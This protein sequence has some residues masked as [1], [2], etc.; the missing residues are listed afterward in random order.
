MKSTEEYIL[1][2]KDILESKGC[3]I[4]EDGIVFDRFAGIVLHK[5]IHELA[6]YGVVNKLYPPE[7]VQK[8]LGF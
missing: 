3:V 6:S 7:V 4:T 8:L 5:D 1:L 2:L